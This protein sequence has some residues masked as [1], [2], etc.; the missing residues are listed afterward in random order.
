MVEFSA[1]WGLFNV[2]FGRGADLLNRIFFCKVYPKADILLSVSK[3]TFFHLADVGS[4]T[5][6]NKDDNPN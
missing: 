5:S 1:E 6:N 2:G 4:L 3:D